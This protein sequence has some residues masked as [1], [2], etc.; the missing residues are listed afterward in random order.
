MKGERS[1]I[2]SL[3]GPVVLITVGGLFALQNFTRYDFGQTWPILLVVLGLLILLERTVAPPPPV[4]P[5]PQYCW[6]QQPGWQQPPWQPQ[7]PADPAAPGGYRATNYAQGPN[8][9]AGA[10]VASATG[11]ATGGFG[12]SAQPKPDVPTESSTPGGGV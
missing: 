1:R 9:P 10:D 2:R 5:P 6:P 3:R 7:P 4:A 12:S 11:A 8:P